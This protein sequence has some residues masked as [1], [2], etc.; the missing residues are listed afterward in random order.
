[1]VS[2]AE[3]FDVAYLIGVGDEMRN[4]LHAY[5]DG[6]KSGKLETPQIL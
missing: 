6:I 1:M 3:L 4:M 2:F 5:V